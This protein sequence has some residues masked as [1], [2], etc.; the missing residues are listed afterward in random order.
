V[1]A[2]ENDGNWTI[3][4]TIQSVVLESENSYEVLLKEYFATDKAS[5]IA[6]VWDV[7]V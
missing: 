5:L 4:F 1:S 6:P 2:T 3:V 7:S